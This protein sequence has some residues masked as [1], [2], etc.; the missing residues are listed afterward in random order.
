MEVGIEAGEVGEKKHTNI[1]LA[2]L[3]VYNQ[4]NY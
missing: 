4:Q 2:S 3:L 1:L